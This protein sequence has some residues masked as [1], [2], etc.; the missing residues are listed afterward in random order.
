MPYYD[1]FKI[2]KYSSSPEGVAALLVL[3]AHI[4]GLGHIFNGLPIFNTSWAASGGVD[5]F[6]VISGFI[7]YYMA[8]LLGGNNSF[9]CITYCALYI[10][11][12]GYLLYRSTMDIKLFINPPDE[13]FN[14]AIR[15]LHY[16]HKLILL[17]NFIQWRIQK[18]EV[19]HPGFQ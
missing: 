5:I 10:P 7:M 1:S 6:F 14:Y 8:D 3:L 13:Y 19:Q 4:G 11:S 2:T 17:A 15:S 18:S 9:Y 12:G 16:F